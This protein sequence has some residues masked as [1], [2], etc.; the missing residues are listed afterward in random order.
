MLSYGLIVE[1]SIQCTSHTS[2]NII[3]LM[4]STSEERLIGSLCGKRRKLE[5]G[6]DEEVTGVE[7][8]VSFGVVV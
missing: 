4:Q 8:K 5:T 7:V 6:V 2:T 1:V 3:S